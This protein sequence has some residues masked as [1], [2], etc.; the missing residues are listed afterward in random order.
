MEDPRNT[1]IGGFS[2]LCFATAT[3]LVFVIINEPGLT[4][5]Q[6]AACGFVSFLCAAIAGVGIHEIIDSTYADGNDATPDRYVPNE[7]IE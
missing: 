6:I 2:G 3:T 5:T 7:I 4:G 1:F